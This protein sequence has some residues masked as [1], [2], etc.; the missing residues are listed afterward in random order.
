MEREL[1]C[2]QLVLYSVVVSSFICHETVLIS[3]TLSQSS[4]GV[5]LVYNI[6]YGYQTYEI[7]LNPMFKST[8]PSE[9]WGKRWN[10]LVHLGLKSG[11]YKPTRRHTSS[12]TLAVLAA[13]AISGLIHEYVNFV[14]FGNDRGEYRFKYKQMIFFGWN[15]V[16]I[17]LE[18]SCGKWRIFQWMSQHLPQ[19]VITALVLTC[20]LPLAHL[21]TGDWVKHGYFDAVYIAEPILVCKSSNQI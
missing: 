8:S 2:L 14:M 4:L 6:I 10:T 18:Y 15:A 7:V 21:F 16:L 11:V 17:A 19:F 5:S 13:F 12:K 3:S 1:L 9:F 20:A